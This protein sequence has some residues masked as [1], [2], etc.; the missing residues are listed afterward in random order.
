M[1]AQRWMRP[2]QLSNVAA[3]RGVAPT[4]TGGTR[5]GAG[6]KG[7]DGTDHRLSKPSHLM[8]ALAG[9]S[10]ELVDDELAAFEAPM[11][12]YLRPPQW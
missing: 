4:G 12:K 5:L 1:T 7:R 9:L 3:A 11:Q 2:R 6:P 8:D 10:L